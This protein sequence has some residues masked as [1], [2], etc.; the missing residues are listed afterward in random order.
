MWVQIECEVFNADMSTVFPVPTA[1][2]LESIKIFDRNRMPGD[3]TYVFHKQRTSEPLCLS[4][5]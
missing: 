1:T 4:T 5:I 2:F 3:K